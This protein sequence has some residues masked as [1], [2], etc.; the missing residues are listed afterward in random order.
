MFRKIMIGTL[1]AFALGLVG[2]GFSSAEAAGPRPTPNGLCGAANMV[3]EA[4]AAHMFEAMDLHTAAQGDAG[5]G[6]AVAASA[7]SN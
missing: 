6:T 4:A 2:L 3:N 1:G 5:M 7:C